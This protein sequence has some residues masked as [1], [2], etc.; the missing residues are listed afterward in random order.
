M[1][2][3]NC[4]KEISD[5]AAVCIHCGSAVGNTPHHYASGAKSELVAG[6]MAMSPLGMFGIHNF[7]LGETGKAVAQLILSL[8]SCFSLA[9]V[10][11][12][13]AYYDGYQL[14]TSYSEK[15]K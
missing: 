4:G 12:I 3:K 9:I 7:Y 8:I 10:A 11:Q 5:S 15:H 14:L 1:F 6:V 13:W 2:C